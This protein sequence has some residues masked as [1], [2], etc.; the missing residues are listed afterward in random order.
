MSMFSFANTGRFLSAL[1]GIHALNTVN[2]SVTHCFAATYMG[3]SE[4]AAWLQNHL[5]TQK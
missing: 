4:T 1:Y 3:A 5:Y 2:A